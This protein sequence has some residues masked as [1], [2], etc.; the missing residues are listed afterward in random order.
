MSLSRGALLANQPVLFASEVVHSV[1]VYLLNTTLKIL[2]ELW[3]KTVFLKGLFNPDH[4][5][6]SKEFE[7]KTLFQRKSGFS[8]CG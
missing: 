5:L 8:L 4:A 3:K 7:N 6:L 1:P 2:Y